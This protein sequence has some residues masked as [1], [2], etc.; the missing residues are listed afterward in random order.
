MS[1]SVAVVTAF[2]L[3]KGVYPDLPTALR[4]AAFNVVSVATTTGFATTDY[5]QWPVFAPIFMLLLCG[6]ATCAGSTGGGV[7]LV[8]FLLLLKQA[9]RELKR[10]L[11]PDRSCRCGWATA[12]SPTRSCSRCSRSCSSTA[13]C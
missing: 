3:A 6:F 11:H 10:A 2:L 5:A 8:R 12:S 9:R 1:G 4:Y 13:S 7:K